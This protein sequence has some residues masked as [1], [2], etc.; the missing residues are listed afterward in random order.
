MKICATTEALD[1]REMESVNYLWARRDLLKTDVRWELMKK[2]TEELF[3]PKY[4]S[5]IYFG[6]L[7][8]AVPNVMYNEAARYSL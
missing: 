6:L 4:K 7:F 1:Q 8:R 2:V 3:F 5:Q